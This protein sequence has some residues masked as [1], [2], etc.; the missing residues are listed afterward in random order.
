MV[1][2]VPPLTEALS[3]IVCPTSIDPED[4]EITFTSVTVK[5]NGTVTLYGGTITTLTLGVTNGLVSTHGTFN[6][7]GG[8]VTTLNAI[9]GSSVQIGNDTEIGIINLTDLSR[10][11]IARELEIENNAL[12]HPIV[13]R[14]TDANAKNYTVSNPIVELTDNYTTT[15]AKLKQTGAFTLTNTSHT[16]YEVEFDDATKKI[17]MVPKTYTLTLNH[18][19]GTSNTSQI[20]VTYD[21]D[22]LDPASVS[23]PTRAGYTFQGWTY[24][25]DDEDT[26]LLTKNPN[27]L[28]INIS[29]YTD[30][31]GNWVRDGGATLYALWKANIICVIL[32]EDISETVQEAGMND[33]YTNGTQVVYYTFDTER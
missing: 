13:V 17:Y 20:T 33:T 11:Y 27:S 9:N 6:G 24:T 5:N 23:D 4:G 25:A 19:D 18:N 26:L 7:Y 16:G 12:K 8:T 14:I 10:I 32:I 28:E 21:S 30:E 22:V 29:G 31:N 2:A 3:V 1:T 15:W